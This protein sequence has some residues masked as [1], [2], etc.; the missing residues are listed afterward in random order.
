MALTD[1][2]AAMLIGAGLNGDDVS[3]P[4]PRVSQIRTLIG[5]WMEQ[6]HPDVLYT[7]RNRDMPEKGFINVLIG[8]DRAGED[9]FEATLL[10]STN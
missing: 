5:S 9:H 10:C 2:Y 1:D 7:V 6:R 3:K 8:F 4:R